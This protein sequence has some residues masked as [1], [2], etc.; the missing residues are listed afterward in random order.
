VDGTEDVS[1]ATI[2]SVLHQHHNEVSTLMDQLR[3]ARER[4]M[5]VLLE[6][7]DHK[8]QQQERF[9][10]TCRA[11]PC[12]KKLG[13]KKL[14]FSTDSCTFLAAKLTCMHASVAVGG[15]HVSAVPL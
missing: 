2:D 5:R 14:Q 3:G 1:S 12:F 7:L 4:Q 6:K 10:F 11:A 15:K 13:G 9:V 8:R